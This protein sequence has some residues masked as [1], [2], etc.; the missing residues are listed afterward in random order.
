MVLLPINF[1]VQLR[2]LGKHLMKVFILWSHNKYHKVICQ[3]I[4]FGGSFCTEGMQTVV[5]T[6]VIIGRT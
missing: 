6:E 1:L 5:I 2:H 4:G 3:S